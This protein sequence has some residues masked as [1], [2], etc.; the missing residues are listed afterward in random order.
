MGLVQR[1]SLLSVLIVH[2][3]WLTG[4]VSV[5]R[6]LIVVGATVFQARCRSFALLLLALGSFTV[7]SDCSYGDAFG[8]GARIHVSGRIRAFVCGLIVR[9]A[10]SRSSCWRVIGGILRALVIAVATLTA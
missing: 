1:R 9:R 6:Q 3:R 10:H 7:Q 5:S 8:A 4:C 2:L